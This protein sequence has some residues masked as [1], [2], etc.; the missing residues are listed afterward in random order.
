MQCVLIAAS[1]D[2]DRY[3]LSA[4]AETNDNGHNVPRMRNRNEIHFGLSR[5]DMTTALEI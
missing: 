2:L 3:S 1:L 5:I 4:N